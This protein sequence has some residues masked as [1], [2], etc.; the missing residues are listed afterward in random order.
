MS[1]T[2]FCT[3]CKQIKSTTDFYKNRSTKDGLSTTCKICD[4]E[5][6]G[7]RWNIRKRMHPLCQCPNCG[8]SKIV[9]RSRTKD[10][11]CNKCKTIIPVVKAGALF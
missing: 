1:E 7:K 9:Y 4:K 11:K 5:R 3:N 2:K 10:N 6:S 8:S